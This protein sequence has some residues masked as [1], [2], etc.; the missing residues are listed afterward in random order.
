MIEKIIIGLFCFA[1]GGLS[2]LLICYKDLFKF[3]EFTD[4]EKGML[5]QILKSNLKEADDDPFSVLYNGLSP[6][7]GGDLGHDRY[8][9]AI[10]QLGGD[11]I[12]EN[13]IE[14]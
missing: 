13:K 1:L 2:V 12:L 9:A 5:R 3:G 8:G 10:D 4:V 7:G 11:D 6:D 14:K